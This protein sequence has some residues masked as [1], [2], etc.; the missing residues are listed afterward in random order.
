M[1][2]NDR[3]AQQQQAII[4][5][6]RSAANEARLKATLGSADQAIPKRGVDCERRSVVDSSRDQRGQ[7]VAFRDFVT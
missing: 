6:L 4:D 2:A 7:V 1:A 3:V 5:Q